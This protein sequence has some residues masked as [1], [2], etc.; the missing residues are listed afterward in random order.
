MNFIAQEKR[1]SWPI[2]E[3]FYTIQ[4]EGFHSGRPAYFIRTGGCD[5]GCVWC[6][7]KESWN[8][9]DHAT[10][11][12]E[13][14]LA[15]IKNV[16][17]NFVVITGGEPA[18][19]K[20]S[21]LVDALHELNIETAIETSGCYQLDAA[22]GWYC[23]SP[24]KF[25]PPLEEAYHKADELKVIIYHKSDFEW[26]EEHAAKIRN[27]NCKLYL[28]PEWSREDEILPAIISYAKQHPKWSISLQTHKYMQIP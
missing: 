1:K 8:A 12:L 23:F 17:C 10:M 19:Y 20:L 14:I 4:G 21:A 25:K 2:M 16:A 15:E 9:T 22:V 6:D 5:V 13:N 27:N 3:H 11:S 26:A 7:V 28:Q 18:M 24:K